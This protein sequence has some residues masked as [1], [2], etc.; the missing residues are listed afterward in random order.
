MRRKSLKVEY[1]PYCVSGHVLDTRQQSFNPRGE[2]AINKEPSD[3]ATKTTDAG[4]VMGA[5]W[6]LL[7]I[8]R[9]GKASWRRWPRRIKCLKAPATQR[10]ATRRDQ[11]LVREAGEKEP[12]KAGSGV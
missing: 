6:K 4:N 10:E 2:Q 7:W 11:R 12:S 8:R 5:G 3:D 1:S 9:S